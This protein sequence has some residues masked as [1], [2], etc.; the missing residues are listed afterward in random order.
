M[1]VTKSRARDT[2]LALL[3][4]RAVG[5]TICPSEVARALATKCYADTTVID[6]RAFMPIIHAS[7]DALV[8][9]GLVRLSWK[10][11]ALEARAG[12]YRITKN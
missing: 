6:W 7:V 4:C 12:P 2:T 5:A 9:E 3:G 10:G 1:E 11:N 8:A